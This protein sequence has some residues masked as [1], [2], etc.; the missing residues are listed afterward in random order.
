MMCDVMPTISEDG[1][2]GDH[3]SLGSNEDANYEQIMVNMLDERDKVMDQLREAQD[4]LHDNCQKLKE[5]ERERD[6]LSK[7]LVSSTSQVC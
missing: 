4:Q 7:Q 2:G 5:T 1:G 3:D 6:A